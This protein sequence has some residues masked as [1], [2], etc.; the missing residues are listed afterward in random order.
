MNIKI[1]DRTLCRK[2]T[3][4]SF[5]EKIEIARQLDKLGVS[6]IEIP[7]I[8]NIKTDTLLVRTIASF[9]KNSVLSVA[10]ARH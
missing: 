7:E 8:E 9:V 2:D 10:V 5:K 6:A 1:A 4:F 3:A